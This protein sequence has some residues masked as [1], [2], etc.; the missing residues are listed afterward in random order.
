MLISRMVF[1]EGTFANFVDDIVEC[2]HAGFHGAWTPQIFG[3]DALTALTVAA[4]QTSRLHLGTAVLPVYP[5]HPLAMAAS[6]MSL[7]AASG[8]RFTLGLGVSHRFIVE[9]S[10]GMPFDRPRRRLAEY[11]SALL[12]AMA[13]QEVRV[14]GD[15]LSAATVRPLSFPESAPPPVLLAALGPAMLTLAGGTADGTVTWLTG[16]RTLAGH[17]VPTI[18]AAAATH[19]RSRPRIVAGLPVCVTGDVEAAAETARQA[20]AAYDH[21]PS[22]RSMLDREGLARAGDVALI[23]SA[24]EIGDKLAELASIGVTELCADIF[25]TVAERRATVEVLC[26]ATV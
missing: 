2:E 20:Y 23:G 6:A 3:W 21:V 17:I 1:P 9:N 8:G 7:Q 26:S 4:Q 15:E 19:H 25:G 22:Y 13:G 14:H 16:L 12:P 24:G 10:W 18:N 11:L 5:T